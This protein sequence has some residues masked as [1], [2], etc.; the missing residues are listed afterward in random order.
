[1]NGF[2]SRITGKVSLV[3][4]QNPFDAVHPHCGY[5]SRIVH[6]NSGDIAHD[7]QFAPFLMYSQ[8]VRQ[9]PQLAFKQP[10]PTIGFLGRK[11]VSI[12]VKWTSTSAPEFSN[13]L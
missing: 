12:A 1:M 2:D 11:T 10:R 3:E 5:Q 6:L 4:C 9:Q 7:K 13:L 8:T